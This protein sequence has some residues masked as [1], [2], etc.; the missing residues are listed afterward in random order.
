[1][2]LE[3]RPTRRNLCPVEQA[4]KEKKWKRM[5]G[6]VGSE[7]KEKDDPRISLTCVCVLDLWANVIYVLEL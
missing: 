6:G 2:N 5:G 3:F 1:M 7:K 4:G